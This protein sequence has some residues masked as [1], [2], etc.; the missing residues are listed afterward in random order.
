MPDIKLRDGSGVEQTYTG[1]D[2]ITVPLADGTGTWTYGLTDE[3]LNFSD[4]LSHNNTFGEGSPL[5]SDRLMKNNYILKRC[6]FSNIGSNGNVSFDKFFYNNKNIVDLSDITM[7]SNYGVYSID[8]MFKGCYNLK[9]LPNITFNKIKSMNISNDVFNYCYS[10][11]QSELIKIINIIKSGLGVPQNPW[12][13]NNYNLKNM[14]FSG[15]QEWIQGK[16]GEYFDYTRLISNYLGGCEKIVYP[17]DTKTKFNSGYGK[18]FDSINNGTMLKEI[19]FT[20]QENGSPYTMNLYNVSIHLRSYSNYGLGNLNADYTIDKENFYTYTGFDEKHNVFYGLNDYFPNDLTVDDVI[21]RYNN[22]KQY[23]DWHSIVRTGSFKYNGQTVN[24]GVLVSRFNH[25]SI[26][27]FIN[28]V[29]DTSAY[30]AT[31]GGTNTIKLSKYQGDLTDEGGVSD[32]TP[33]E[34]AVATAKGWTVTI[35]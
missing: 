19:S 24:P 11:E 15:L 8:S 9:K 16:C 12:F 7:N 31:T 22:V 17:V 30:L 13:Y 18:C 28:T 25:N 21:A 4:G 34:I 14:D 6:D 5:C 29:P 35:I 1:V 3:E 2:T 26:V 10:L 20:T 33:E 27:K 23:Q 32:L